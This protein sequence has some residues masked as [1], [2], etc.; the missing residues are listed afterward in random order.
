MPEMSAR[1]LIA[2]DMAI[3]ALGK[4]GVLLLELAWEPMQQ[5][6]APEAAGSGTVL[7]ALCG[8]RSLCC[9]TGLVAAALAPS[10]F[11]TSVQVFANE[12]E[13]VATQM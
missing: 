9:G 4:V 8:S 10:V 5:G 3:W 11:F 13:I 6:V 1:G 7:G 12:L 2:Q